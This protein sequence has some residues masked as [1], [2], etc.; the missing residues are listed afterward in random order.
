[1]IKHIS[2]TE[3]L[4]DLEY[5]GIFQ[6]KVEEPHKSTSKAREYKPSSMIYLA[7]KLG[8]TPVSSTPW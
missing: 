7:F 1:M 4:E 8:I 6:I 2:M 5:L 3:D